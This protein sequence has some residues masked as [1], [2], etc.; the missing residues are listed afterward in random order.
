VP[1]RLVMAWLCATVGLACPG[2]QLKH[3]E[4]EDCPDE[5]WRVMSEEWQLDE[6]SPL[7]ALA[8]INQPADI[9]KEGT[10][11]DGPVVGRITEGLGGPPDGTLLFG[12][13]WTGR[14][15]H[16]EGHPAVIIRYTEAQLPDGR[17][18][19][20]CIVLGG[21]DGRV[22]ERKGSKPGAVRLARVLP[23]NIVRTFP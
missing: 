21:P 13:I 3:P 8:D 4:R 16:D 15:I 7:M 5:A 23:A 6:A 22:D 10:Y 17:R 12:R 11:R 14:G 20:V 2:A 1:A 18:V 9:E 19:P